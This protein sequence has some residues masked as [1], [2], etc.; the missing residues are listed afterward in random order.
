MQLPFI[1][2]R[3]AAPVLVLGLAFALG[4][5]HAA[6][7]TISNA[8]TSVTVYGG[9]ADNGLV[10]LGGYFEYT[11][12]T[13]PTM[14]TWSIDP[15]LRF[16][17]GTTVVLSNGAAGG[18][19]SPSDLG[20]GLVGSSAVT[21]GISVSAVTEL[22]G[23]I[24][25]TRFTF[26]AAP[27][28]A[29]TGT[30]FLFYAENDIFGFGDDTAAFTGSIAGGDLAL[31]QYDTIAGSTTVRLSGAAEA[32]SA[33]VA[34][35]SGVWPGWGSALEAGD[36]SSLS[37]DGSTFETGPGDLGLAL[38][39]SLSGSEASLVVDYTTQPRPPIEVPEPAGLVLLA[40]GLAALRARRR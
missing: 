33:L 40:A 11:D 19:G 21:G 7:L 4:A 24:A 8:T 26:T 18:F 29:L 3:R 23:T 20:G 6:P 16:A 36:F 10:P 30:S 22:V 9:E 1:S 12:L 13:I 2:A 35:G 38:L 17:D 27:G 37:G 14:P 34:F 25:R 39:F 32:G 28:A 5:A 31:F 15:V